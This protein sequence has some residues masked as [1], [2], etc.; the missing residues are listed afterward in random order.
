MVGPLAAVKFF[1]TNI[2]TWYDTNITIINEKTL[3]SDVT[4]VTGSWHQPVHACA[5]ASPMANKLKNTRYHVV[6]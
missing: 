2:T 3:I 6:G 4:E 1:I 5:T